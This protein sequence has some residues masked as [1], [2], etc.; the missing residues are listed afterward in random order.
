M[1]RDYM[2]HKEYIVKVIDEDNKIYNIKTFAYTMKEAIDNIVVMPLITHIVH[3]HSDQDDKKWLPTSKLELSDLRKLRA[4]I[5]DEKELLE[6][7]VN[8]NIVEE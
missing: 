4:E 3:V 2:K 6:I 7:L 8:N 1:L 5:T